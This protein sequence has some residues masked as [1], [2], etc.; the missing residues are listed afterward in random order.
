MQGGGFDRDEN[1]RRIRSSVSGNV[2]KSNIM[3]SP[4]NPIEALKENNYSNLQNL[5]PMQAAGMKRIISF[6]QRA[7]PKYR[8][9]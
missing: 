4:G 5:T 6:E 2:I 7:K 1:G 9:Q 8:V 3:N